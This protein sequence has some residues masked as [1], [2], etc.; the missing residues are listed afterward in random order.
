MRTLRKIAVVL[1]AVVALALPVLADNTIYYA[2][3]VGPDTN[4]GTIAEPVK[5]LSKLVSLLTTTDDKGM[6]KRGVIWNERLLVNKTGSAGHPKVFGAYGTGADPII[7]GTGLGSNLLYTAQDY[8]TFQDITVQNAD[9]TYRNFYFDSG[10][11]HVTLSRVHGIN[12]DQ[13]LFA[14]GSTNLLIEDSVFEGSEDTVGASAFWFNNS[15]G[16]LNYNIFKNSAEFPIRRIA[17]YG[18]TGSAI[19]MNN[20]ILTGYDLDASYVAS[21]STFTV[22][23]SYIGGNKRNGYAINNAGGTVSFNSGLVLP[24][25]VNQ[26]VFNGTVSQSGNIDAATVV[27]LPLFAGYDREGII[28]VNVDD[29]DVDYAISLAR[30]AEKYGYRISY[31]P[32]QVGIMA[33]ADYADKLRALV[34]GGAYGLSGGHE[35]APHSYSHS[36][37]TSMATFTIACTD[38]SA[39]MSIPTVTSGLSSAW[40]GTLTTTTT[41]GGAPDL[42]LSLT[43]AAYDTVGELCAYIEGLTGYTCTLNSLN[44]NAKS[45]VLANLTNQSITTAYNTLAGQGAF[46]TVE[47][48]EPKTWLED[49]IGGG[50][51]VRSYAYPGGQTSDT[52]KSAVKAAGYDA[53][54]GDTTSPVTAFTLGNHTIYGIYHY[55]PFDNF[56]SGT[57]AE[58]RRMA[59][60]W[61][62]SMR[63]NGL[64]GAMVAHD[65]TEVTM[66]Q[67]EW[68][69]QVFKEA[70]MQ[71]LPI[72]SAAARIRESG[73]WATADDGVTWTRT[74]VPAPDYRLTADSPLIDAGVSVSLTSDYSG[75]AVPYS[76]APDIGAYESHEAR[77]S[78]SGEKSK[79][80]VWKL[81]IFK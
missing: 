9:P 4:A 16:A 44:A 76:S 38:A 20:D 62:Q 21:L 34:H 35:V 69:F 23:N 41:V 55:A 22:N 61:V 67:W 52:V 42:S 74:F 48:A 75:A 40:T 24:A 50:Y 25:W 6:L 45:T 33:E 79:S 12:G 13:Q 36:V 26:A 8:V 72:S 30:L 1:V 59:A 80:A 19:T 28:S 11:D 73:L 32:D 57:L 3:N 39:V 46:F 37:L 5:T 66:E 18:T 14:V 10:S 17:V 43:A 70:D 51:V 81:G 65:A 49:L 31:Y 68:I 7:D 78:G 64:I 63:T 54:R 58:V 71:I 27:P 2:D 47:I 29:A 53:G 15:S 77:T 56:G 60:S